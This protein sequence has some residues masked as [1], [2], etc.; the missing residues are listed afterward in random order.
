MYICIKRKKTEK[1]FGNSSPNT[2]AAAVPSLGRDAR[3]AGRVPF[4]YTLSACE[5]YIIYI[6]ETSIPSADQP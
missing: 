6:G 3:R 2:T 4:H 5:V 1:K